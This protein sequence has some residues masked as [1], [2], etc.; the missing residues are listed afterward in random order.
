M[1]SAS[2]AKS[3]LAVG[4]LAGV[5]ALA[6]AGLY[7]W[8]EWQKR[9]EDVQHP[10]AAFA[11][12]GAH[13]DSP[14]QTRDAGPDHIRDEDGEDWDALDQA[15]DESFP[16]SDPPVANDFRTPEP[17]DYSDGRPH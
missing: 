7:L 5:G 11:G 3:G 14:V 10:A 15:S 17:I 4:V 9:R 2:Y 12:T 13:K 1:A 16:S 6:G 8:R